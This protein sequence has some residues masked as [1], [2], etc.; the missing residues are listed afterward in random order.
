MRKQRI[1]EMRTDNCRRA[2]LLEEHRTL[3]YLAQTQ[4]SSHQERCEKNVRG[5]VAITISFPKLVRVKLKPES[6]GL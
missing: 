3:C 1:W 5:E 6:D 2:Q 4:P